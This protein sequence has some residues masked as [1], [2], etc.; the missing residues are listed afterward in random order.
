MNTK[1]AWSL[2][3]A[4][5]TAHAELVA[6]G[7]NLEVGAR[8]LSLGGAF[9]GIADDYSAL[10]YNP[11]GMTQLRHSEMGLNLAYQMQENDATPAQGTTSMRS[12]ES[13]RVGDLSMVLTQAR[14]WAV[15]LG[16]YAPTS[17]DDPLQYFARGRTYAYQAQGALD[18]YRVAV[19]YAPSSR[20][21]VGFAATALSGRQQLE[22]QDVTTERY[23]DDYSGFNLEPSFLL[24]L[25]DVVSLGGS[26]VMIEHLALH[27]IYQEQGQPAVETDYLIHDPLQTR[28][29]LAFQWSR[30]QLD[31]D[32]HGV[33]W[34]AYAY[35]QEGSS[36]FQNE[37]GYTNQ[38]VFALGVEQRLSLGP[39]LRA[40]LSWEAEDPTFTDPEWI[41]HPASFNFGLGLPLAR[42][43]VFDAG[44]RYLT[45]KYAQASTAG[46]PVDLTIAAT[47]QQVMGSLRLRW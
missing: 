8:A 2:L 4:A 15:G 9:T 23:L 42:Y 5:T 12:L 30:T 37:P 44:Y 7:E 38:N 6:R 14:G 47:N 13:T 35:A 41:R 16:Y 19:A 27:D 43:L 3:L 32:W 36:F 31:I 40:G 20:A 10:Y 26:A 22:I 11:A 24:Q 17:F 29:G 46:G 21:S 28:L 33:F 18:H 39:I 25:S 1:L 34:S 45:S